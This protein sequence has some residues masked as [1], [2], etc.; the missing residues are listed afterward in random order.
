[1][2]TS[3]VSYISGCLVVIFIIFFLPLSTHAQHY[4]FPRHTSYYNHIKPS[5][6]TQDELDEHVKLFYDKWKSLYLKNGCEKD[7]YYIFFD[8]DN[9]ITVSEAMGYGMMIIPMMAGYDP[10]AKEYFDG[11]FRYYKAHP[12][13]KTPHLMAWKQIEGCV[14]ADGNDSASDGDIDIAFGLLL[15]HQQWGSTGEINYLYHAKL[16]MD[17]LTG[18]SAAEGDINQD[19]STVKLGDWVTSGEYMNSTRTSDFITDHFR[20]F[21]CIS[22]DSTIWDG[23]IDKC[24]DLVAK[25]QTDFSPQTGLLPDFIINADNNPEPA[26][27]DFLEGELDGQYYYNACRDPWR[28]GTDYLISGDVRA[29]NAVTKINNWLY[30]KTGGDISAIFAG[31]YLNGDK[32]ANW[33]DIAFTAPFTVGAMLDSTKQQ[34]LNDLYSNILYAKTA[35]AG[36]YGNTIKLLSMLVISGN[37]LTPTCDLYNTVNENLTDNKIRIYQKLTTGNITIEHGITLTGQ[38]LYIKVFNISGNVVYNQKLKNYGTTD[39]SI[40]CETAGIYLITIF[41]KHGTVL[42]TRKIGINN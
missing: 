24:Y 10:D 40:P 42:K 15:A 3:P 35:D 5:Q 7:Q 26:N 30:E 12:S 32:A 19:I 18:N 25:M 31:Y 14:D 22:E 11:L 38:D 4:P 28:L 29:L 41:N 17:D 9:T 39:I 33:T 37:Y 36:Y 2:K 20:V 8:S 23:V 27:P 34:W 16:I 6:Y 13:S 1:M 21:S